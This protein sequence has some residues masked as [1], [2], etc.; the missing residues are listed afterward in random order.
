METNNVSIP[1]TDLVLSKEK[2][3]QTTPGFGTL[4][5]LP[6]EIRTRIWGLLSQCFVRDCLFC[7]GNEPWPYSDSVTAR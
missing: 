3:L 2:S 5:V 1:T 6:Y 4:G 7:Y